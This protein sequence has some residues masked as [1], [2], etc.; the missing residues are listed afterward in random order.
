MWHFMG[1]YVIV[2][3]IVQKSDEYC[4][5]SVHN[6]E[7]YYMRGESEKNWYRPRFVRGIF[8]ACNGK[9]NTQ[10]KQASVQSNSIHSVLF[11][12]EIKTVGL[13]ASWCAN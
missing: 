6:R 10:K 11:L 12:Y 5:N 13:S 3:V 2:V 4:V 9:G 1:S 7:K 8:I